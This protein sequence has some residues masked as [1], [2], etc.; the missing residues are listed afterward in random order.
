MGYSGIQLLNTKPNRRN[1]LACWGLCSNW[2]GY[3]K[4]RKRI[5]V[6]DD[7]L[8]SYLCRFFR[9]V[10]FEHSAKKFDTG[11]VAS[12]FF[13]GAVISE[14]WTRGRNTEAKSGEKGAWTIA[15]TCIGNNHRRS[16]MILDKLIMIMKMCFTI[17]LVNRLTKNSIY[18]YGR[19][20]LLSLLLP[21]NNKINKKKHRVDHPSCNSWITLRKC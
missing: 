2:R 10:F 13:N 8:I 9:F 7:H 1:K 5:I 19:N 12:A 14:F 3:R 16:V 20:D 18:N 4:L 6:N 21:H 11:S 17:N 15:N